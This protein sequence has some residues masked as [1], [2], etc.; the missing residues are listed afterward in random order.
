M[1]TLN[2]SAPGGAHSCIN[3][4]NLYQMIHLILVGLKHLPTADNTE[5]YVSALVFCS[6]NYTN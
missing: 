3:S 1:E 2:E 4:V 6:K 5:G